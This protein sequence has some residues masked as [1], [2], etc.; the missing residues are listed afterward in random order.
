MVESKQKIIFGKVASIAER[1]IVEEHCNLIN[2]MKMKT[3]IKVHQYFHNKGIAI[4]D[5]IVF[6]KNPEFPGKKN[7]LKQIT[8]AILNNVIGENYDRIRKSNLMIKMCFFSV[9]NSLFP[10]NGVDIDMELPCQPYF[11]EHEGKDGNACSRDRPGKSGIKMEVRERMPS[12]APLPL[13]NKSE[14]KPKHLKKLRILLKKQL[15]TIEVN[16]NVTNVI[17]KNTLLKAELPNNNTIH[18]WNNPDKKVILEYLLRNYPIITEKGLVNTLTLDQYNDIALN[19]DIYFHIVRDIILHFLLEVK[20]FTDFLTNNTIQWSPDLSKLNRKCRIYLHKI[21]KLAP[22]FDFKRAKQNLSILHSSL[23]QRSFWPQIN[24]QIAIIIYVTDLNNGKAPKIL[25][26]NIR[27]LC[28]SS[29]Y[30]FHRIR[31]ILGISK[32]KTKSD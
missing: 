10:K 12:E 3:V 26:R 19:T 23:T 1:N 21:H 14:K 22:V 4:P 25:Q 17:E 8:M 24:N 9:F 2:E 15:P 29:A 30:A 32:K 11:Q 7:G 31:N 27:A 20:C 13:Q 6:F 28:N 18:N 5:I 16:K